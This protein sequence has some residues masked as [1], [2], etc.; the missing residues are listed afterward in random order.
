[1]GSVAKAIKQASNA[2]GYHVLR[3]YQKKTVEV[4]LSGRDVF[5]S[6]PGGGWV[7]P[8]MGYIGTC[9]GIG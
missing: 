2:T 3:D 8:Y 1:M 5:V 6:A 9:R 7:L 4:Y